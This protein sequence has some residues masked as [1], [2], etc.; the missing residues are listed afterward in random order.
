MPTKAGPPPDDLEQKPKT[1]A[2]PKT[3]DDPLKPKTPPKRSL[4]NDIGQALIVANIMA[5]PFLGSD[6]L[7]DAEILA[8]AKGM[9]EQAKRSP[10]FRRMIEGA[11]AVSG[12]GGLI[13][14]VA[15]IAG[16]RLARHRA[17]DP[18]WD[19]RLEAMLRL[20]NTGVDPGNPEQMEAAA[21]AVAAMMAQQQEQQPQEQTPHGYPESGIGT[22]ITPERV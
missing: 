4:A 20:Q 12:A 15:L 10:R 1:G 3:A 6:A 17:I 22:P 14:V 16:R 7:D 8:L 2:R 18:A 5:A 21:E 9:D 13:G 11:L 19:Q